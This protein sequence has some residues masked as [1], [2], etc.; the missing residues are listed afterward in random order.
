V[1]AAVRDTQGMDDDTKRA[2]A[3]WRVGVLGPLVS[4]RLEHGDRVAL[5]RAAAARE[6]QLPDGRR[7]TLSAR[8]IETWFHRYQHGGFAALVPKSR[9]D[10]DQSRAIGPAVADLI[11][12]ARREKPRRS[13]RRIIRL[14]ERAGVVRPGELSRSSVHRLL[15]VHGLSVRP[16]RGPSAERRSFLPAHAG[17]L[18]V[19]DAL[20]GPLVRAPDG[21]VRKAY[22]LS[23]ID[24]ATRF[25]VHSYFA[26]AEDAVAH[27]HALKQ[28]LLKYGRPRVYYV[29][30]GAA[31]VA[32]SLRLICAELGIA[33]VHTDPGDC[34]AK[35][36]IERFN[37]T[38]RDEVGD[39]LPAAPLALDELNAR[40]WAWLATEY[41]ARVHDTTQRV[42]RDHWLAEVAQLRPLARGTD[43][44]AVFLHRERRTVRK[45]GTVR[46]GGDLLEVRAELTGQQVELRFDP[47][48]PAARPRVFVAGRF[49]CDTVPLD[50]VANAT[51][52]RRR[53][54]GAPD[55]A[56]VPTGLDPLGL[57][58]AEHTRRT[59]PLDARDPH[60]P[61]QED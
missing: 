17:D 42:P 55:P 11:L 10:Q 5:F 37:R 9:R 41:H 43:L 14:L 47:T 26:L 53:A 7:V 44:A 30:L 8:T 59:R 6:H 60:D 36:V 34:E 23:L 29:D 57:M 31:Y 21:R 13:I 4:A 49:Y 61:D 24:A 35:G 1:P 52:V 56:V 27:E 54:L 18:W 25:V 16:R 19:G 48:D 40:H 2:L 46:F 38:W 20:H 39:E 32:T 58:Q 28:A 33:L 22:K 3:L 50:R 12:R 45:D 51:R 15:H